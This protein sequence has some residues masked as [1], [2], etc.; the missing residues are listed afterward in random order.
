MAPTRAR[1]L[2]PPSCRHSPRAMDADKRNALPLAIPR[3]KYIHHIRPGRA[4]VVSP[5]RGHPGN[6]AALTSVKQRCHLPLILSHRSGDA[7]VNARQ[8]PLPGTCRRDPELQGASGHS[9][10]GCLRSRNNKMLLLQDAIQVSAVE[11][12]LS[13]HAHSLSPSTDKTPPRRPPCPP[14][15]PWAESNWVGG[16]PY[17]PEHAR[18]ATDSIEGE[19]DA[20][21]GGWTRRARGWWWGWGWWLGWGWS[22]AGRG[23]RRGLW[24]GWW[25]E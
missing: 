6:H 23:C 1:R 18:G 8:K 13:W 10:G 2:A 21:A 24:R 5:H 11:F 17:T 19:G 15:P 12:G 25:S 7:E 20:A 16:P 3:N 14:C 4:Q 9:A 22:E